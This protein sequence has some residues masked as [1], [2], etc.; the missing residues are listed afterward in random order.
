MEFNVKYLILAGGSGTRLWPL[1]RNRYP[2]Q[3]LS[4]INDKS[5]LQNTALRVSE[6]GDDIYICTGA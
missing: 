1:S 4:L 3:F 2:K 5:M 6:R